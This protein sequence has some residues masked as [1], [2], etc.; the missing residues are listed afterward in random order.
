MHTEQG[1]VTRLRFEYQHSAKKF[2]KLMEL[3]TSVLQVLFEH[4]TMKFFKNK[5]S[6]FLFTLL[7][8]MNFF[9][10]L[11]TSK[12]TFFPEDDKNSVLKLSQMDWIVKETAV[13]KPLISYQNFPWKTRNF[14]LETGGNLCL[15]LSSGSQWF[16]EYAYFNQLSVF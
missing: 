8:I 16:G 4:W 3:H 2:H 14:F 1:A 5:F 15:D 13:F 10:K 6:L 12:W 11:F 9:A 7:S